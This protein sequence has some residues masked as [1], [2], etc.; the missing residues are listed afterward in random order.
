VTTMTDEHR[1]DHKKILDK[2]TL[3]QAQLVRL[4]RFKGSPI[5]AVRSAAWTDEGWKKWVQEFEKKLG[6]PD[7][8]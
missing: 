8:K 1:E 6:Q 2:L 5:F 3:E 4:G 7:R